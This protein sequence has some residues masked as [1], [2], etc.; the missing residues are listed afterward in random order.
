MTSA[1]S[2][3]R[4][5][6]AA[7]IGTLV[8]LAWL[9]RNE[10]GDGRTPCLLAC[11]LGDGPDGPEAASAAVERLLGDLGLP[12]GGEPVDGTSRTL[13]VGMLVAAGQIVL[14]LPQI[15]SQVTPPADWLA[16]VQK[17]GYTYFMFSKRVCPSTG[18]RTP[19]TGAALA[20]FAG[21]PETT[22]AAAHAYL[23]ARGLR[24]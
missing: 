11:S 20:E 24:V 4:P 9:A 16:A 19:V 10:E 8:L 1:T 13:K 18:P 17:L 21:S 2:E 3:T 5:F 15:T 6:R 22:N 23:P 12:I 14:Q 7:D